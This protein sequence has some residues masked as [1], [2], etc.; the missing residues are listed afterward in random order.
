MSRTKQSQDGSA[1]RR[2]GFKGWWLAVLVVMILPVAGAVYGAIE[3]VI[4]NG[5][6]IGI[7]IAIVALSCAVILE[8]RLPR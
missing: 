7:L 2:H 1:S 6:P 3:Y 4:T 5:L 8:R